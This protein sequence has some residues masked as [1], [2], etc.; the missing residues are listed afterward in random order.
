MKRALILGALLLP[1][2][3]FAASNMNA[4]DSDMAEAV[5][6]YQFLHNESGQQTNAAAYF[7]EIAGED[8]DDAFMRRFAGNHPPIKKW[9]D[10]SIE[11]TKVVDKETGKTG[12]IFTL[13]VISIKNDVTA[14]AEGGYYEAGL[15][16]SGNTYYLEKHDGKWIVT[17]DTLHF[18]K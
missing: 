5:F 13:K 12:L 17:K 7:L 2:I 16:A 15:S 6:R 8:P 11:D 9:S 18:I 1:A 14:E 10:C 4:I 3:T